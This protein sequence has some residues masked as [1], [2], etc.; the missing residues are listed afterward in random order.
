[1]NKDEEQERNEKFFSYFKTICF[2]KATNPI[3]KHQ[4]KYNSSQF[5]HYRTLSF[6]CIILKEKKLKIVFQKLFF[7]FQ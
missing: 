4:R 7:I 3:I 2:Q 1:M 6:S 5:Y